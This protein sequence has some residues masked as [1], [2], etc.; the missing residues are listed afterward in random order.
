M[1]KLLLISLFAA[2]LCS[3]SSPLHAQSHT[4]ELSAMIGQM[5]LVGF[6]GMEISDDMRIVADI[7][8]RN[9]GG[10]ILFDYDVPNRKPERNISSPAQVSH[11]ITQLQSHANIPL[12]I[13][14]DQEGGRVNR[15]KPQ[16][17]FPVMP[18]AADLGQQD[19]QA[20]Q[21]LAEE[22][23]KLLYQLGFNLNFAPVADVNI[24]PE[25]PIIGR[26]GRSFSSDETT[27]Y[28][29]VSAFV[30]GHRSQNV[31]A[32]LKHFPG[33]GS[34]WND[35]HL[36]MADVT[37]TW[38]QNELL[39]FQRMVA[40]NSAEAIMTAHIFNAHLDANFPATLSSK[41]LTDLLRNEWGYQGVIIS[42]DMQMKAITDH[43]GL[44]EAVVRAIN[45]GVD[46]LIFANNSV[47]DEKITEQVINLILRNIANG[48]IPEDR[49][50]ASYARIMA[51]KQSFIEN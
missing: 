22:W 30:A 27:V 39:P 41:I 3:S 18:S 51:L 5:L 26:L 10:V 24:N 29:H 28:Q 34:A 45:A 13:A 38:Q 31:I 20:T 14:V 11:L 8:D 7:R 42:D 37:E 49:I 9:L 43:F 19:T 1:I 16:F 33:H 25:N 6:R 15:L 17:G 50:R 12:F 44:E 35:S 47:Y 2:L 40:N 4:D 23:G 32:T 48:K 46:V 21:I 36:G